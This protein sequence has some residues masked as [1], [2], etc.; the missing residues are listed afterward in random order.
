MRQVAADRSA[1]ADNFK[2]MVSQMG[3]ARP[4][5]SVRAKSALPPIA[6]ID[7]AP[8][9]ISV[10][11][12]PVEYRGIRYTVRVR[13]EREQWSVAIYPKG[14]EMPGKVITGPRE[15]AEMLAHSS[16]NKW[17][18]KHPRRITKVPSK[19]NDNQHT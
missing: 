15:K 17:L 7:I 6:T 14:V 10:Q 1:V 11:T 16:I 12:G 3:H 2:P 19:F 13:I 9:L 5:C 4:I 18:E 8:L